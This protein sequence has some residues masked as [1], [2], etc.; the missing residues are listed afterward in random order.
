[1][2][3]FHTLRK[4]EKSQDNQTGEDY[5][6]SQRSQHLLQA[7]D[8]GDPPYRD[9]YLAAEKRCPIPLGEIHNWT[10]TIARSSWLFK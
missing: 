2:V 3:V 7:G 10:K 6:P 4:C 5:A 9:T 8:R 1:M